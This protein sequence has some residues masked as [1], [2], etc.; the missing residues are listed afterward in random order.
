V[1]TANQWLIHLVLAGT[2]GVALAQEPSPAAQG[3]PGPEQLFS[4]HCAACHGED[5]SGTDR[6]PSLAGSR[7][8][9]TRSAAEVHDIIRHGTTG[10]MP[11]FALPENQ[12]Q[13]LAAF[14]R[15]MN[16]T[17][18]DAQPEGDVAAGENL[19]F[20]KGRCSSCHTAMGRGKSV[21]PD[22]TGIGREVTVA[23]IAR[24]LRNP[25]AQVAASYAV[26]TVRLQDGRTVRGF[27]RKE[28]L[29]NLQLQTLE[30]RLLLLAGNEY[31]IVGR[32]KA[33]VMPPLQAT[34]QEERDLIAFLSRL[35]GL[36]PGALPG[37]GEPVD[38]A[39][40]ER[41]LHPQPGE[42]PTYNGN[43]NGNRYSPLDQVNA[44]N[45]SRLS[46]QWMYTIP[47]FGLETT[48][49][50]SDGVMY[51]TGPN[52]VHALDARSGGEI[53]RYSR[54]RSTSPDIASDAARGAN[55]GAALLGDRVFVTTDD[56]HLL[57]LDRLT[58]ALRWDVYLPEKPEHYG[59]T[60]APLVAGDLVI[61]GVA[62]ADD[63]IR[64]FLAAYQATTG[65][66]VWRHWTIPS[67]GEPGSETWQGDALEFGGGS[68]W[69]TGS[70]DPET[71][72]LYWAV[73][74]PY[75][76]TDGSARQGDNLYTNC[77]LAMDLDTGKTRWYFQF[78]PHDLHDWDAVQPMVLADAPF[79]GRQRKLLIHAD[80]NGFFYI[81]DRTNGELLLAKA[82]AQKL[83]WASG[84]DAHG[85]PIELPGNVPTAEGT[86]TCP[87]IRGAANWMS[88]AYDPGTGLYYV[89]TIENCGVYRSTQFGPAAA[90][91]A[92][93]ARGRGGAG[94]GGGRGMGG[95][96]G[97]G[98]GDGAFGG[99]GPFG[100]AGGDP[101]RRYLRAL[102]I[103]T[104]N[105]AWE[106][107]QKVPTPNYGGV[108]A[109]AGGVVFYS[110]SS[111][112]FAAV[113][114]KTGHPL[115][116]FDASESPKASPMTYMVDG[117]QY[118]AIASGA[119]I[120]SFA[121]PE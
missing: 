41:I 13:S 39:A 101:P 83:S 64:G 14:I 87:D 47:Y 2:L 10:G 75:P 3:Q 5:A 43:V 33:S 67:K 50:V 76:D 85:R 92:A 108:L 7:R 119:N 12:L 54:P 109:T 52:Q 115:W 30:G 114:A 34:A 8:L 59:G 49:L 42:W 23:D 16:A 102:D 9:R 77:I 1:L 90:A 121:L 81:L 103:Q 60:A 18:F 31:Q 79:Q 93:A 58:G 35:G 62:G 25:G 91:A 88:T 70:Y 96:A 98:M 99:A 55:R 105:I 69:L 82:F 94:G 48:P 44:R 65:Q 73:G 78:T 68:T 120:L 112:A 111:G 86:R 38:A 45:A 117:R 26:V 40:T 21:G 27:A 66:L 51:V 74:N 107:E 84:L 57:C 97:R 22:L 28:T 106:I 104:G 29:H 63:G 24:K 113:D 37:P 20:G 36:K 56:A 116:H 4:Q 61:A 32:E 95:G 53:W 110:E 17:A 89:M 72:V 6:G 118:V 19:F 71:R 15:S 100:G 11:P 46:M 80:R